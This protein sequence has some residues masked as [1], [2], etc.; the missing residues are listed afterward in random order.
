MA[1]IEILVDIIPVSS[2]H[3]PES[4]GNPEE[5]KNIRPVSDNSYILFV[6]IARLWIVPSYNMD[7]IARRA[8]MVH[9]FDELDADKRSKLLQIVLLRSMLHEVPIHA[10]S[11]YCLL[12]NL[13]LL[14]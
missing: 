1:N 5:E 6:F 4:K 3:R 10:K 11:S 7:E 9:C 8:M 13:N 2:R 14:T 12:T